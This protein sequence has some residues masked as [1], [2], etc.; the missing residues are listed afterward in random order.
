[1]T[2]HGVITRIVFDAGYGLIERDGV[3]Y[4][5]DRRAVVG[6]ALESLRVGQ[7]VTFTEGGTTIRGPRARRVMPTHAAGS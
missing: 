1:M 5:F 4:V 3:S 2:V 6:G 7:A